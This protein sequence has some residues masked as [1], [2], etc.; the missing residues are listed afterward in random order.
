MTVVGYLTHFL[1]PKVYSCCSKWESQCHPASGCLLTDFFS[2]L[3][4][5]LKR[6]VPTTASATTP[7]E[8]RSMLI[9]QPN[10]ARTNARFHRVSRCYFVVLHKPTRIQLQNSRHFFA[11]CCLGTSWA[12][13]RSVSDVK[14]RIPA[15]VSSRH[16][17]KFTQVC[18]K[19]KQKH[20]TA[21]KKDKS[22]SANQRWTGQKKNLWGWS[23]DWCMWYA[24]KGLCV[25]VLVR[26]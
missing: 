15:G 7:W 9:F 24:S 10:S 26:R 14:V 3:T 6:G 13:R 1:A 19:R 21:A 8:D 22:C 4:G 25:C 16:I 5:F 23:K 17:T 2:L 12:E 20:A 18:N 11:Q